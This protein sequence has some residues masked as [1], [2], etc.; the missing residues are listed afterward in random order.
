MNYQAY[1][2][3]QTVIILDT[4]F[5]KHG[6]PF[7]PATYI[8]TI[9]LANSTHLLNCNIKP[10]IGIGAGGDMDVTRRCWR[11]CEI[12]LNAEVSRPKLSTPSP[13]CCRLRKRQVDEA[14]LDHQRKIS[15]KP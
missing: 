8:Q 15:K 14:A 9:K 3:K 7:L 11:H 4:N 5:A 1:K 12:A 13:G 2:P 10:K 6:K